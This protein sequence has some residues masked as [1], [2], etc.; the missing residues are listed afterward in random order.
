MIPPAER[1]KQ[2]MATY[3]GHIV[4]GIVVFFLAHYATKKFF[5][6]LPTKEVFTLFLACILGSLFPD[7]DTK[8]VGQRI[9]YTLLIIPITVAIIYKQFLFLALLSLVSLFPILI[10]H[11]GVTHSVWFISLTP[12]CIPLFMQQLNPH[13][14]T[15]SWFIYG[16]FTAGALSHLFLDYGFLKTLK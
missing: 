1:K 10:N 8:S 9:F 2:N 16:Y 11:R 13:L 4:G 7:I 15:V 14:T 3:K 5:A 6:P 12:L